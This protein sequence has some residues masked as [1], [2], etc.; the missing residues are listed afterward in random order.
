MLQFDLTVGFFIYFRENSPFF[1]S[2][3]SLL[4]MMTYKTVS[5]INETLH[6]FL[7]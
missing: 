4:F 5:V 7:L 2:Y 1:K 3:H 6:L